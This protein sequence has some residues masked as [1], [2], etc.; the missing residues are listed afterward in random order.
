MVRLITCVIVNVDGYYRANG[1]IKN[2]QKCRVP[3]NLF[4][5]ETT[6]S[7]CNFPF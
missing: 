7:P 1:R 3:V 6:I 5:P 2:N 4:T